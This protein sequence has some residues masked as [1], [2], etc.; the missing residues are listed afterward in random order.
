VEEVEAKL[1]EL[2]LLVPDMV[3]KLDRMRADILVQMLPDLPV[4]GLGGRVQM[5]P[6]LPVIE[7]A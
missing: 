4:R 6:D 3:G 2:A 1:C 5:L 7:R